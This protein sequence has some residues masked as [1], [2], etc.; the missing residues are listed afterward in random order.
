MSVL[1]KP[2]IILKYHIPIRRATA[3]NRINSE[4]TPIKLETID[5]C[6][7]SGLT[8]DGSSSNVSS[9]VSIAVNNLG[10]YTKLC[11]KV[12]ISSAMNRIN[13]ISNVRMKEVTIGEEKSIAL[14]I[15]PI[16]VKNRTRTQP[17]TIGS[18]RL[19]ICVKS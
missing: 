2:L 5:I 19:P 4:T 3:A 9:K 15:L 18:N 16:P 6:V 12:R 7:W 13:L 11:K 1:V 14:K 8:S 10:A 17:H